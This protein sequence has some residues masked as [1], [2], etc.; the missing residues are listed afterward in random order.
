MLDDAVKNLYGM[1][2]QDRASFLVVR[3][4]RAENMGMVAEHIDEN[5]RNSDAETQ[6][7]TE[8]NS[9]ANVVTSLGNIR[10]IIYSLCV[11]VLITVLLVAGNSMAMMVR[12]RTGEVGVMRALG[13]TPP[14][15]AILL[16]LEAGAIGLIGAAFGAAVALWYFG[17]GVSL[18]ALTGMLGYMQVRPATAIGAVAVSVAISLL[19]AMVPIRGALRIAPSTAF[20]KVV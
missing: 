12:D 3:V 16:A 18:G 7:D 20:R 2:L 6:T 5:F 4:D 1:D 10:A 19:S 13:F 17:G 11:V 14:H 15:V 8:S 9:V